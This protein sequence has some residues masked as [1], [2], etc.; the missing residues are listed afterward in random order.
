MRRTIV[1]QGRE[2]T[3]VL[4]GKKVKNI[5]LR[6]KPGGEVAVSAPRRMSGARVDEAVREKAPWIF[7]ALARM[8]RAGGQLRVCDG[9]RVPVNGRWLSIRVSRGDAEEVGVE[10]DILR[11][12]LESES[13]EDAVGP[14]VRDWLA[15]EARAELPGLLDRCWGLYRRVTGCE[16]PEP[17][18]LTLRWMVSRWGSCA[19]RGHRI[20]LNLALVCLPP[21]SAAYV[22][23]HELAH[24]RHPDHSPA[25]HALT[26]RLLAAAGLPGEAELRREM[27]LNLRELVRG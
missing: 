22:V 12:T 11:V 2:L 25:F 21:P 3:Y 13:R 6:V 1:V 15:G 18:A 26:A 24:L 16:R 27:G 4:T 23:F 10:G 17:P 5:N 9:G 19:V 20:T 7:A 8:E 14:R